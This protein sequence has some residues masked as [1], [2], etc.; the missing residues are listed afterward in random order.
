MSGL[1]EEKPAR[2]FGLTLYLIYVAVAAG[3]FL[4]V[5]LLLLLLGLSTPRLDTF[6]IA[7]A[8]F[9]SVMLVMYFSVWVYVWGVVRWQKWG[10]YGIFAAHLATT[11]YVFN[12]FGAIAFLV[13]TSMMFFFFFVRGKWGHFQ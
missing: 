4:Y 1:I 13:V 8:V 9:L 5:T 12:F 6:A 11:F 3:V 2:G 10:V 7:N